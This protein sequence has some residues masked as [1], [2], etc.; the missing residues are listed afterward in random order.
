MRPQPGDHVSTC[1]VEVLHLL[2]SLFRV[3]LL[4]SS[5]LYSLTVFF[6]VNLFLPFLNIFGH[7]EIC[8]KFANWFFLLCFLIDAYTVNGDLPLTVMVS[9]RIRLKRS[10]LFFWRVQV[11]YMLSGWSTAPSISLIGHQYLLTDAK[12]G[13]LLFSGGIQKISKFHI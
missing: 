5:S 11:S 9:H 4:S 6:H 7:S 1:M 10:Y 3:S 13:Q 2:T 12:I 8:I